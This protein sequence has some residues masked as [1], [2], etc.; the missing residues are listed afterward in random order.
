[1]GLYTLSD[2]N[3]MFCDAIRAFAS[4]KL[5]PF[6][7]EAEEETGIFPRQLLRM[8]GENGF[9]CPHY[10]V[11]LDGGSGD[12]V[13]GCIMIEE[14]HGESVHYRDASEDPL[15]IPCRS[16]ALRLHDGI[17]DPEILAG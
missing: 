11:E 5:S 14:V 16:M 7:D 12:K 3:R 4:K 9:L 8:I 6:L 15:E 10:P 17:P 2:E 13:T 1:M